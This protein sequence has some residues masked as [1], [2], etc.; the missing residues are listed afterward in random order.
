MLRKKG[1]TQPV[2]GKVHAICNQKTLSDIIWES[3]SYFSVDLMHRKA[4]VNAT[5]IGVMRDMIDQEE[6]VD[7]SSGSRYGENPRYAESGGDK[8]DSKVDNMLG[9]EKTAPGLKDRVKNSDKPKRP[10]I[11]KRG[12]KQP[13]DPKPISAY[14]GF[15]EEFRKQY[16]KEHPNNK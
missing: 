9:V 10:A 11:V 6:S 5:V 8:S 1:L 7:P 3:G 2:M 12:R 16:M 15:Y 13:K 14:L 4:E